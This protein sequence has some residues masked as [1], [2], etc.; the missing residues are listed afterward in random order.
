MSASP[1]DRPGRAA[2][3]GRLPPTSRHAEAFLEMLLVE[4]GAA[5]NTIQS[6]RRDLDGFARFAATTG[7]APEGATAETIR[8]FLAAEAAAGMSPR[9]TA[10]RLSALRQFYRFLFDEGIRDDDPTTAI[11][12]PKRGRPLPKYLSEAEVAR[13]LLPGGPGP[14]PG[15]PAADR[16]G[17]AAA[18]RLRL[19]ALLEV[20]YATGL[21]V[22]ELVGLPLSALQ[23]DGRTLLVRGKGAKER[24][25]PLTEP[26]LAALALYLPVRSRFVPAPPGTEAKRRA[27]AS[28]WLFPSRSARG[29][30]T[31]VRFGQLLKEA[32]H[33]AGLD[34]ERVSPHVLRHSFA[35]HLLAHGADLRS[36]Q[37]MLGHADIATT[38][39]YTHILAERLQ[40]LVRAAHPLARVPAGRPVDDAADD[41]GVIPAAAPA[42]SDAPRRS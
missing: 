21:R 23:R 12:Q 36:V 37:Q 7:V 19:R 40:S 4:R 2:G 5:R 11:D 31:R 41:P 42:A 34:P 15:A 16:D 10:R 35:S 9:T 28:P 22:S 6:Y 8:S 13:L 38:Q 26:A 3:P 24:L 33:A 30:L 29:H 39:V 1:A 17:R 25:V 20:L 32:A 27:P 14:R 18:E